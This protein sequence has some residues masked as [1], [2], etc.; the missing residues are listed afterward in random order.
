MKNHLI[1][2]GCF[3]LLAALGFALDMSVTAVLLHF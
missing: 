1:A 2:L 3:L